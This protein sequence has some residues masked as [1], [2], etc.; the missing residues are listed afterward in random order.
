LHKIILDTDIGDDIDDALALTFALMSGKVDLLG[1]TTV[2]RDTKR[3]AELACCV[4]EALGRTEVPVYAGLGKPLLQSAAEGR[5]RIASHKPRQMEALSRYPSSTAPQAVSAVDFIVDTVMAGG[6][7]ITLVP[8]GPFTNVAA[9]LTVEPRLAE[10]VRI[11][12]MGGVTNRTMAEWNALCDPEATRIV[13]QSGAPITMVG[14]DV[15]TL[16]RMSTDQVKAIGAVDRP[17]NRLCFELIHLWGGENPDP[18][19][20]LHDPLAVGMVFDPSFC[21]TRPMRIEVETR[22][23]NLRGATVPDRR[24]DREPNAEVCVE[25]DSERFMDTFVSTLTR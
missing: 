14:L 9:A 10:R 7:D 12:L 17:I 22:A 2:F 21:A 20:T 6:G 24:G 16:C 19:P 11:C 23:D 1:V 15:T 3:R 13:F 18:R 25:V 5:E 8:V 4:L